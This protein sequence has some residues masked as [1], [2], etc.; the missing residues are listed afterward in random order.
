MPTW[1]DS[2]ILLFLLGLILFNWPLLPTW[3]AGNP[4]SV[5]L[6]VF[7]IWLSLLVVGGMIA[8]LTRTD[9]K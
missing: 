1:R 7:A 6:R 5:A 2:A 9:R 3:A 4:V 8:E